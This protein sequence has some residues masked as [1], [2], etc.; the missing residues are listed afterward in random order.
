[1]S[2]LYRTLHSLPPPLGVGAY[3]FH[4]RQYQ[5]LAVL[6]SQSETATDQLNEVVW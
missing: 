2:I 1:M 3:S 6:Q 5:P 4:G